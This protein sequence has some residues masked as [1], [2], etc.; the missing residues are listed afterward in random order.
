MRLKDKVAIITGAGSGIGA[1][2]ARRFVEEG[3]RVLIA[4]PLAAGHPKTTDEQLDKLKRGLGK[5]QVLG[6]IGDPI[7]IANAAL[8][9]ASDESTFITGH[10]QVVD[11]G[12]YAG[13]P[14]ARQGEWIT[15]DRPIKMY[16]P[17]ER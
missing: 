1:E 16:R 3:A 5:T 12:A 14:W 17:A 2:S 4:T 6:R 7:D 10:T 15:S 13:K 11:G 8:F 9:L